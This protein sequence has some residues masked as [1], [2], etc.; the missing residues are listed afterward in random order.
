MP[1][2]HLL[3]LVR[4]NI[5]R[6]LEILRAVGIKVRHDSAEMGH[7]SAKLAILESTWELPGQCFQHEC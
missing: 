7:D 1:S 2:K 5:F 6:D 4:G 3:L